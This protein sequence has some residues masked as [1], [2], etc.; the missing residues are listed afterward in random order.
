MKV[1]SDVYILQCFKCGYKRP[2]LDQ[3]YLTPE[4]WDEYEAESEECPEC[5]DLLVKEV[6]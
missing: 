2:A 3:L 5:G 6:G 1:E 4:E